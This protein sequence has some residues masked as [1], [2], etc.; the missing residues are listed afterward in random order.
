M[1]S[2]IRI[3]LCW[4]C[5]LTAGLHIR[6][7]HKHKP[8]VNKG[9]RK[10]KHKHAFLF[11]ALVLASSRFTRGL[12]LCLRRMCKP[13]LR[14]KRSI[15]LLACLYSPLCPEVLSAQI[16]EIH[17]ATGSRVTPTRVGWK[18]VHWGMTARSEARSLRPCW[19][20]ISA[21]MQQ[22]ITSR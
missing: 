10:H 16:R 7:K 17:A 2:L 11:L 12:C 6:R 20:T 22:G 14:A 3:G 15:P 4:N 19:G 1:D 8:R 18:Q 5:K 13:A 21:S 9:W